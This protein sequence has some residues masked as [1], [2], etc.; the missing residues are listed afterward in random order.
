MLKGSFN[1]TFLIV[2]TVI[3]AGYAS[4][5]ELWQFFGHESDLAILLFTICFSLSSYSILM[6]SYRSKSTDYSR[7]LES[8]VGVRLKKLYDAFIFFYLVATTIVMVAGA[9]AVGEIFQL[10]HWWGVL[11]LSLFLLLVLYFNIRGFLAVN[12]VLIPALILGLLSILLVYSFHQVIPLFKVS[13]GQ[14][15][16]F[17]AFPFT[18]LNVLPL[19]AVL[20]AVGREIKSKEEII[21]SSVVS[22]LLLGGLTYLYNNSLVHIA[23]YI[24]VFQIPLF[25]IIGAYSPSLILFVTLILFLAIFTTAASNIIG[26]ARRLLKLLPFRFYPIVCLSLFVFIPLSRIGFSKLIAYLY[27]AYGLLNLYVLSKLIIYPF[28]RQE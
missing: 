28:L 3:G 14:G 1:W 9:G 6:I 11:L 8:I 15:N 4:G 5:R 2:G 23:D 7:I 21:I 22:G 25:H 17:A 20:G 26:I 27:P 16:W 18:S 10:S 13:R 19:I 24:D 12:Q